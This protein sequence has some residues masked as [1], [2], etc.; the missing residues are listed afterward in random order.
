[1]IPER[2]PSDALPANNIGTRLDTGMNT[3]PEIGRR[4]SQELTRVTDTQGLD[5]MPLADLR[6]RLNE[7]AGANFTA[8]MQPISPDEYGRLRDA[9]EGVENDM[10][11]ALA[12]R[13]LDAFIEHSDGRTYRIPAC[14]WGTFH[15]YR[16]LVGAGLFTDASHGEFALEF[17]GRG[18]FLSRPQVEAKWPA[19]YAV[20]LWNT[21]DIKQWITGSELTNIK[22]AVKA[23]LKE[24]GAKGMTLTF[25]S[26]WRDVHGN[27]GRGRPTN[28]AKPQGGQTS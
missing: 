11:D 23:F 16:P 19:S 6:A 5:L 22:D 28:S 7:G 17:N 24:S 27:R 25:E 26:V 20:R 13:E 18:V 3:Y 4:L 14:Y 1:M 8:A 15:D 10:R 9:T 21:S 12:A 2:A